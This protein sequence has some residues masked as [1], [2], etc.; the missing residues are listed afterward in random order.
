MFFGKNKSFYESLLADI[1]G[2]FQSIS[3][4]VNQQREK[5][6][7]NYIVTF[8]SGSSYKERNGHLQGRLLEIKKTQI[9]DLFLENFLSETFKKLGSLRTPDS[10]QKKAA[11]NE[12]LEKHCSLLSECFE[13]TSPFSRDDVQIKIDEKLL[14]TIYTARWHVIAS[15][16]LVEQLEDRKDKLPKKLNE[17]KQQV[18]HAFYDVNPKNEIQRIELVLKEELKMYI[19]KEEEPSKRPKV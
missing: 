11:L 7:G 9:P 16:S 13:E 15:Y 1:Q 8:M 14:N 19:K 6:E 12:L 5:K 18:I 2:L 10:T 17:L 4:A 3:D